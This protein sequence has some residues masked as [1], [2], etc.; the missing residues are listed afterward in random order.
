MVRLH[1]DPFPPN[2]PPPHPKQEHRAS[3]G[4][5]RATSGGGGGMVVP[6]SRGKGKA[7]KSKARRRAID[8]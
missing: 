3:N 1:R 8:Y 7:D 2:L 6:V 4:G 5:S